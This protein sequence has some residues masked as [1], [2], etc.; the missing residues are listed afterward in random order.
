M[1]IPKAGSPTAGHVE[2][3]HE[4]PFIAG[5]RTT[6]TLRFVVGKEGLPDG[7]RLRFGLPN[8]GWQKPVVPQVRYWSELA[9]GQDRRYAPFHPVNTTA[10]VQTGER[11]SVYLEVTERM[12]V[13]DADPAH[14]Y[15]RWW[16]TAVIEDGD[17][18]A[19]DTVSLTYG[20][21]RFGTARAR[22]QTFPEPKINIGVY[23]DR[24]GDGAYRI[25]SGAPIHFDVVAGPPSR[26]NAVLP[27]V[28]RGGGTARLRVALTDACHCRP[29]AG[30]VPALLAFVEDESGIANSTAPG[31]G[32]PRLELGPAETDIDGELALH[33][34]LLVDEDG[35]EWGRSNRAA[36]R[37]EDGLFLFW[38]DLHG[39]SEHHAMHSTK[40]DYHQE[41]WS[42][43]LSFGT[44]EECYSYARDVALLDFAA[45]TD[46]GAC[47]SWGWRHLQESANVFNEPGRFVTFRAYEAGSPSG[48]RNVYFLGDDVE[49]AYDPKTFDFSPAFLYKFYHGRQDVIMI[50]HHVKA[51]TDWSYHDPD[52]EPLMEIYSCWGQSEHPGKD[53]WEKGQ[54]PGAGA[55]EAFKRGYRLGLIASSDNHVGMPGRSYP[56]DRQVHTAFPGGLCAVWAPELTRK[57][58]FDALK[59]RRCY[60]TTGARI[61]LRF[62]INGNPMGSEVRDWPAQQPRSLQV[63]VI[64][65]GAV[66]RVEIIRNLS[67]AYTHRG[68]SA[69]ESF[70]WID[71]SILSES[72]AY[73]VRVF[74][75]N[76]A[77]AWSSPVWIDPR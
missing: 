60:G 59:A 35:R 74:E 51:W 55:W 46:Q 9:S 3:V 1:D 16:I 67:V 62:S 7:A 36:R 17:L 10:E 42:K 20:D 40:T 50:P 47:L 31:S 21:P 66:E 39:Q 57:S 33:G 28:L 30:P 58:L 76:G 68:R 18:I 19:G 32:V 75:T 77:R 15:W 6:L 43:G 29:S 27:S 69:S 22:I 52:L 56:H 54:T 25:A 73:Y 64:C 49:P 26:V 12:L 2:L 48:H 63:Q 72:A 45:L 5:M 11:A 24:T 71:E 8:T 34:L 38:G 61:I 44:P 70:S 23:V 65:D 14:A 41:A 4:G 13:P 37:A 53:L